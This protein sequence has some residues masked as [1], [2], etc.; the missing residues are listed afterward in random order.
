[1]LT[2][3]R[4]VAGLCYYPRCEELGIAVIYQA[5]VSGWPEGLCV[6]SMGVCTSLGGCSQDLSGEESRE[7]QGPSHLA[8][9]DLCH[10]H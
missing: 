10:S 4:R 3:V 8:T 5:G 6:T 2:H 7:E 1:M 9:S